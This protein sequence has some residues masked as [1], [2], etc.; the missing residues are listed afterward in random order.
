MTIEASVMIKK[1]RLSAIPTEREMLERRKKNNYQL[2]SVSSGGIS[3]LE[4]A[5]RLGWDRQRIYEYETG[6]RNPMGHTLQKIMEA[7]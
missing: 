4:L 1:K 5:N 7:M 2:R 3:Q 6:R